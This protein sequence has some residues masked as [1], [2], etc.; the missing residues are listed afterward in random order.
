MAL[1]TP[2]VVASEPVLYCVRHTSALYFTPTL[3]LHDDFL[4]TKHSHLKEKPKQP[5]IELA[6]SFSAFCLMS[7]S[8]F[9]DGSCGVV[10][11]V[12]AARPVAEG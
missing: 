4:T 5:Y 6:V 2:L 9:F 8:C 7:S 1:G 12:P 10:H 11:Q 3:D